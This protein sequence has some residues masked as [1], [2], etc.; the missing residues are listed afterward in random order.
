MSKTE[1]R[2][3]EIWMHHFYMWYISNNTSHS[4]AQFILLPEL[5]QT[6][7]KYDADLIAGEWKSYL[8]LHP[9][10]PTED[11]TLIAMTSY[12]TFIKC[13]TTMFNPFFKM[14]YS[15][16]RFKLQAFRNEQFVLK[17]KIENEKFHTNLVDF[18]KQICY[19]GN[20]NMLRR[21]YVQ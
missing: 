6:N 1:R 8:M 3:L 4:F 21:S 18:I 17:P 10:P 15:R 13:G 14:P 9:T 11:E 19:Y 12:S 7:I 16:K 5:L 20:V 2:I